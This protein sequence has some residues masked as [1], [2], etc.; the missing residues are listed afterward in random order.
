[1]ISDKELFQKIIKLSEEAS[2]RSYEKFECINSWCIENGKI[3][4]YH[5]VLKI[6]ID[7]S[8]GAEVED[9]V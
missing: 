4:A 1:M 3:A 8:N 5:D 7:M 9:D 6:I 2:K